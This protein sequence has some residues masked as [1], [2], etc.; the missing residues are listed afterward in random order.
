METKSNLNIN[1]EKMSK[2]IYTTKKKLQSKSEK[3]KIKSISNEK[4][5]NNAITECENLLL[6][7]GFILSN[8]NYVGDNVTMAVGFAQNKNFLCVVEFR[9]QERFVHLTNEEF[10][11]L[12]SNL[13]QVLSW[14]TTCERQNH[15]I[16]PKKV[17]Y[18]FNST[19]G[20][21]QL[22]MITNV[23]ESPIELSLPYL[24]NISSI[25]PFIM[26]VLYHNY[27]LIPLIQSY[28]QQYLNQCKVKQVFTLSPQ[29]IFYPPPSSV[30]FNF[31]RL[32]Y[33]I[34]YYCRNK[35]VSDYVQI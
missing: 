15:I 12:I 25:S 13:P 34:G 26:S 19:K 10:N 4:K 3:L 2:K 1:G 35:I 6:K 18:N 11:L 31:M 32:F 22:T 17:T 9:Y 21:G 27:A 24:Y 16:V 14:C 5:W 30:T 29:D 23:E 20:S 8:D 7:Y 28:Y 33:E